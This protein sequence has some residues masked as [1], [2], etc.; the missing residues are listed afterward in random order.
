MQEATK[1]MLHHECEDCRGGVYVNTIYDDQVECNLCGH[2]VDRYQE[3]KLR[4]T[5]EQ[6]REHARALK[7]RDTWK[8]KFNTTAAFIRDAKMDN[9]AIWDYNNR[10]QNYLLYILREN[11][12]NLMDERMDI[13][14]DLEDTAYEWV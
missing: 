5:N 8:F 14:M 3:V 13:K 2:I 11:A 4:A 7:R 1:N 12:R 10:E 6:R 9:L